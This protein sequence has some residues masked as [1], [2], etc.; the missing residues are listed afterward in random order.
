MLKVLRE[1]NE[2]TNKN[3]QKNRELVDIH[4]GRDES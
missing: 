2:Q 3:K 4:D 1:G